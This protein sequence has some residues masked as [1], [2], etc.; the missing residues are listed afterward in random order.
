MDKQ[1]S[2]PSN[3]PSFFSLSHCKQ[4]TGSIVQSRVPSQEPNGSGAY[5]QMFELRIPF[6]PEIFKAQLNRNEM[7]S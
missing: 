3:D 7:V 6:I 1:S 2:D 5:T 4:H